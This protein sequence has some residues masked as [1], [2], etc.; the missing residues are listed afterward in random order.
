MQ[1]GPIL[2]VLQIK[3][4]STFIHSVTVMHIFQLADSVKCR[5]KIYLTCICVRSGIR[6]KTTSEAYVP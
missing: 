2:Q 5:A 1:L 3:T 6:L 4:K